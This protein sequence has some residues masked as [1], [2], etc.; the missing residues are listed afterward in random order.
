MK[1]FIVFF[2]WLIIVV[3]CNPILLLGLGGIVGDSP[4]T[5]ENVVYLAL[6]V[7]AFWTFFIVVVA[8]TIC[9]IIKISISDSL[10]QFFAFVLGIL[11]TAIVGFSIIDAYG[12]LFLDDFDLQ[13]FWFCNNASDYIRGITYFVFVILF[14]IVLA[15]K[16]I[17]RNENG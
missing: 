6:I 7:T 2:K 4:F 15:T 12:D 16:N 5:F 3:L 9:K 8:K 10:T 1:G 11:Y 17:G 13:Y 14:I